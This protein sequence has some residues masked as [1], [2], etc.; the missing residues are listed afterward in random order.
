MSNAIKFTEKGH[1]MIVVTFIDSNLVRFSI[2]DTGI[3]ID[4]QLI[5]VLG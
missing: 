2:Q 1:V 5:N 4:N 3:G